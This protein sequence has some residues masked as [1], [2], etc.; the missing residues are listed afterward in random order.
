MTFTYEGTD[1][2]AIAD[3]SFD[4]E[5]GSCLL[6]VGPSGSGKSTLALA[7]AG[8]VPRDIPGTFAGRMDVADHVGMVFQDPDRQLVM[9]RVEDDV[10]FGLENRAWTPDAMRARV[11]QALEAVGLLGFEQRRPNRLSGGE[12]QRLALAGVLAPE[13]PILVFDEPTANLDPAGASDFIELIGDLRSGRAATIVLVEHRTESA[14]HVADLVLALG[15]DGRPIELGAPRDVLARSRP[16]LHA[17]GIWL[18]GVAAGLAAAGKGAA[19]RERGARL[20]EAAGVGFGYHRSVPVIQDIAVAI[21]RG[22]RVA[23]V[24]PNGSGKSTLG[25]LFVGLLRPD[26]GVIRL[27]GQDPAGL[28][29]RELARLAG[30]VFQDPERQFLAGTVGAEVRLGLRPDE[31]DRV[32]ELMDRLAL[33]LDRFGDRSPYRLS[34][35]EQRRLSLACVLVRRPDLLVLDEPTFGQDRHGYEGLLSI[36]RERVGQGSAIVAATH[37]ERFVSDLAER[38]VVMDMGRIV[39]QEAVA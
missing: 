6:V 20:V 37:D 24:G 35:G 5:P 32:D 19:R 17:A 31:L 9:E 22:E 27:E 16:Q 39:A 29:A 10:A 36:L 12:Q 26:R 25:R 30:Y 2:P 28:P 3:V 38:R 8:L 4:V 7:I 14:W 23:L 21:A 18:P 15:A 33:P 1:R 13:P 34:G 11:P